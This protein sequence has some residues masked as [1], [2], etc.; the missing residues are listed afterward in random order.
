MVLDDSG[1]PRSLVRLSG[2]KGKTGIRLE[3]IGGIGGRGSRLRAAPIGRKRR[4]ARTVPGDDDE[5]GLCRRNDGRVGLLT[6]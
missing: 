2:V 4:G 6:K 3:N 1:G 5:S